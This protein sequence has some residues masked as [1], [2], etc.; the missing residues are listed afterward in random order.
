MGDV[1]QWAEDN[2]IRDE[3]R[4]GMTNKKNLY[5]TTIVIWTEN[6]P[7]N[8]KIEDLA[9]EVEDGNAICSRQETVA[10]DPWKDDAVDDGVISFFNLIE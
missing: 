4:K 10:V 2:A 1:N 6:D 7:Q 8:M 5:K 9:E 3:G